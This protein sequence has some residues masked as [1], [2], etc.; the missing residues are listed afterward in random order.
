[1]AKLTAGTST[2]WVEEW[3]QTVRKLARAD[4][5]GD[6]TEFTIVR[7]LVRPLP[8]LLVVVH[9]GDAIPFVTADLKPQQRQALLDTARSAQ[10]GM[11]QEIEARLDAGHDVVV[12]HRQSTLAGI[13]EGNIDGDRGSV[14]AAA[15][16]KA[17]A[18]ASGTGAS[19]YGD[20]L[21]AAL[22]WLVGP[23][24]ALKRPEVFLTGAYCDADHGC[25]TFLGRGLEHHGA[26]NVQLSPHALS[27][28]DN[29]EPRWVPRH[30][31]DPL[32]ATASAR[33]TGITP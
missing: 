25:V 31:A 18:R 4:E 27:S 12:L 17:V 13:I 33:S 21:R 26:E 28:D 16:A 1:M 22:E 23:G 10:P 24:N 2:L 3:A 11:A 32:R 7:D 6:P 20:D 30:G 29:S 9:P 5:R 8:P 14:V 19:L 15:F